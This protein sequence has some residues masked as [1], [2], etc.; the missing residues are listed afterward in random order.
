M[1]VQLSERIEEHVIE[2][3]LLRPA[4][5]KLRV[6]SWSSVAF[7]SWIA[8]FAV[9]VA[10]ILCIC[11][12]SVRMFW[13]SQEGRTAVAT[14]TGCTFMDGSS[15]PC[16]AHPAQVD[17]IKYTFTADGVAHNGITSAD[18]VR[19][20]LGTLLVRYGDLDGQDLIY[21]PASSL[22]PK[23]AG[24]AML[25]AF[26]IGF[27]C[28]FLTT[29][30]FVWQT[31]LRRL[32][33]FGSPVVGTVKEKTITD[34]DG[35]RYYVMVGYLDS[36]GRPRQLKERCSPDQWRKLD[37]GQPITVITLGQ[38]IIVSAIYSH[39]PLRCG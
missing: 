24:L 37:I 31:R 39:L 19:P 14:V 4:P 15:G 32:V 23:S 16:T 18:T 9:I 33:R 5:R 12:Q 29:R 11:V 34:D 6:T 35:A 21:A 22:S 26:T 25:G 38:S 8:A 17:R 1:S 7:F 30:W 36:A 28:A 2:P 27:I 13:L 10:S 20:P 3:E